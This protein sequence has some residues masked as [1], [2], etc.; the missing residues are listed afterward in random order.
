MLIPFVSVDSFY[1]INNIIASEVSN[2]LGY[3]SLYP[4][5]PLVSPTGSTVA[6]YTVYISLE[7]VQLFGSASA[8]VG[9]SDREVSNKSNGPISGLA[10]AVSKG[11]KE[12]SNIPLIGEYCLGVSWISDRISKTASIFGFSKPTAGDSITKMQ[13]MNAP[14]H[15]TID[16][17]S[18]AKSLSFLSK[19]GT[20]PIQGLSG[21][22][23]DEMDFSFIK[24]KYAYF[25]Q[26]NW[27][28]T[29]IAGDQLTS[30]LIGPAIGITTTAISGVTYA[31]FPPVSF[32]SAQFK[33]W[34]G[35]MRFR[36]KIV[37]TE[38]HSGRLE[39]GFFP[40]TELFAYTTDSAYVNRVIVDIRS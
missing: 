23:Y 2:S 22:Q 7:N 27:A 4:Y 13:L 18:D 32:L 33:Y 14:S 19:P 6:N 10:K 9:V 30:I 29:N 16:G 38:Y 3:L 31:N 1:P 24:S 17:D 26:F 12:F 20:I 25:R 21:T 28:D 11:F 36:F 34:R 35:S 8:Q 39:F 5:S 40:S 37:K 15:S